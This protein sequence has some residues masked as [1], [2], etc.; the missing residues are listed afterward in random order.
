MTGFGKSTGSFQ[1]KKVS[2]EIRSLNSKSL[3]LNTRIAHQYKELEPEIRKFVG[4]EL[5]RGKIDVTLSLDSM[6]EDKS[7]SINKDL[8]KS[9][10]Q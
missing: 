6:G 1:S 9:Y 3:D 4:K 2:I 5:G 7:V 8:A 10:Y